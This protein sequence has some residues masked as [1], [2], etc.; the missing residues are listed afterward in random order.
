MNN[1][2]EEYFETYELNFDTRNYSI[3]NNY[4]YLKII[5]VPEEYYRFKQTVNR[6]DTNYYVEIFFLPPANPSK[7]LLI[8]SISLEDSTQRDNAAIG[9]NHGIQTSG[10]PLRRFV[11]EDK[12]YL[13]KEQ[14]RTIL[15]FFDGLAA[16]AYGE[17]KTNLA[18]RVF[19]SGPNTNNVFGGNQ[20]G[21]DLGPSGGSRLNYRISPSW[22]AGNVN[23]TQANYNN[24]TS[25]EVDN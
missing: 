7:Y 24:L 12:L 16:K 22:G 19:R 4:E 8:D 2:L 23:N 11:K 5:P 15:K 21:T 14:L 20:Y 1:I 13:N 18:S 25:V 10:I 3:Y 9:T 17:Y 6:D